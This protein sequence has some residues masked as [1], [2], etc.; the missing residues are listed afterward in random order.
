MKKVMQGGSRFNSEV[1]LKHRDLF[2]KHTTGQPPETLSIMCSDSHINLEG[3]MAQL[4]DAS[5]A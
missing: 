1:Y 2:E 3:D 5:A 4:P